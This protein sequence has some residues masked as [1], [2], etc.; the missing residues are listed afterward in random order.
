MKILFFA[1]IP[2][3]LITF[4]LTT[5]IIF[6]NNDKT[7]ITQIITFSITLV[8]TF[9]GVLFG[10]FLNEQKA[11]KDEKVII[12]SIIEQTSKDIV[13]IIQKYKRDTIKKGIDKY[14]IDFL[15]I[16]LIREPLLFENLLSNELFAKYLNKYSSSYFLALND[17]KPYLLRVNN[18]NED[19]KL[20]IG[21]L[22]WYLL[23]LNHIKELLDVS[24]GLIDGSKNQNDFE[25]V[26]KKWEEIK[27]E[28]SNWKI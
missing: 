24:I 10:Y 4:V 2:I 13:E 8:G 6:R 7:H 11:I 23:E 3:L 21:A 19:I 22:D 26:D 16:N 17:M 9:I 18:T 12:K 25:N 14:G 28:K 20:R 5:I 27:K 1:I 15:N